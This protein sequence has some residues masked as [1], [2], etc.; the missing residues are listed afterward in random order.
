MLAT[1]F[2]SSSKRFTLKLLFGRIEGRP[3]YTAF[4]HHDLM[5]R[6]SVRGRTTQRVF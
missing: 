6:A 3:Y 5:I 1:R 2:L 4:T